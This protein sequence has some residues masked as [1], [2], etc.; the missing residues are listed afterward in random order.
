MVLEMMRKVLS[1]VRAQPEKKE[2]AIAVGDIEIMEEEYK[3]ALTGSVFQVSAQ[4]KLN[5]FLKNPR[6]HL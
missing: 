6:P 5:D 3:K 1:E 2:E 4:N